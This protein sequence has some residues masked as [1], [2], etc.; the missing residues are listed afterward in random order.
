MGDWTDE[1][2]RLCLENPQMPLW[3]TAAQPSVVEQ[4]VYYDNGGYILLRLLRFTMPPEK[5]TCLFSRE[6]LDTSNS[7]KFVG[8][9][10]C[11]SVNLYA[12]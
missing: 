8:A 12:F 6:G 1:L 7:R 4:T 9:P 5:R 10:I 2:F 3:I 11:P